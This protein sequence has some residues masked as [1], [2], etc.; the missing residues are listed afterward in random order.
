M[1]ALEL[2]AERDFLRRQGRWYD[3]LDPERPEEPEEDDLVERLE[4]RVK[5]REHVIDVQSDFISTIRN[6][7]DDLNDQCLKLKVTLTP[8][9]LVGVIHLVLALLGAFGVTDYQLCVGLLGSCGGGK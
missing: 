8:F 4:A 9:A 1:E 3:P 2:K 6:R 5:A 7:C